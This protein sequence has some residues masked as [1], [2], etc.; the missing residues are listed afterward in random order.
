MSRFLTG[1]AQQIPV[2]ELPR[3][4]ARQRLLSR[5]TD[6]PVAPL[7]DCVQIGRAVGLSMSEM[8]RLTG[9]ARQTLYRQ[10]GNS[11]D[12]RQPLRMQAAVEVLILL[13]AENDFVSPGELAGRGQLRPE[14]VMVALTD[15]AEDGLATLRR[16]SYSSLEAAPTDATREALR[17]QFDDL[18]LRRPDG[19]T[20]YV[21]VPDEH[22]RR[23]AIAA[24]QTL[25]RHEH[26]VMPQ[27]TVPSGD[28]RSGVGDHR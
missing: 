13:A 7:P 23:I 18:F 4:V 27:S 6:H 16:D 26:V 1:V 12:P 11:D 20:V 14:A 28:A 15:L 25:P 17:E 9:M 22:Q 8:Q 21:R 5:L 3:A 2:D 24:S 19:I 10:L